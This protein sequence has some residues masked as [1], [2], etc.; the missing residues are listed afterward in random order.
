MI[1]TL[2]GMSLLIPRDPNATYHGS[3]AAPAID[4]RR[5]V[6]RVTRDSFTLQYFTRTPAAT[7]VEVREGEIPQAAYTGEKK[8]NRWSAVQV[9]QNAEGEIVGTPRIFTTLQQGRVF[10]GPAG[11]R[12]LHTISVTGL[13][14]GKR[15]FYRIYDP[16][17]TPTGPERK[18]GA[19]KPWRR[20]FAVSTQA[21]KGEKTIIHL[22]VKVILMPNVVN[23]ESGLAVNAPFPP[24]MSAA[25]I[26]RLRDDYATSAR[27]LWMASGMRLWIDYQIQIDDRWLRWGPEPANATGP[28]KGLPAS[29]S[30]PG[31]DYADPGGGDF[32]IFDSRDPLTVK[33]EPIVE[34]RPFS[35]QVEQA[36]PRRWNANTQRWDFYTS[37]GGTLGVDSFPD[38]IPGRSQFLGGGDTAWLATHEVHHQ[39]ESHGA[40]SLSNREDD[41]I[42]FD[43]PAPR[44]RVV[45]PNGSVNENAW[46]TN[47][48]HG[49]HWDVISF[50]DRQLTDAQW[51]RMYFGYT[52][53]TKDADE[54]GF[55]DNDPRLPL[56]E[57]RFGST[58]LKKQS[59]G[60][61]GDLAKAM[62][63]NWTPGP[64]QPTWT[65]PADQSIR[66]APLKPDTDGDGIVDAEDSYPL[67]PWT[68]LIMPQRATID[69]A[70]AE[71]TGVSPAATFDK[72]GLRF[73]FKQSHD[74]QAYYG[75][76]EIHGPWRR[77]DGTFDAEGKGVYSEEGVLGFQVTH[78]GESG[79]TVRP[80]FGGA[81]GLKIV[82]R[83]LAGGGTGIEFSLPNRGDGPWYWDGGGREI[84]VAL[85]VWDQEMR[86]Y[87]AY[88]PYRLFYARMVESNGE[89]PLPD[90]PPG[91]PEP[92]QPGV[93]VYRPGDSAL[94]VQGGWRI[95][96]GAWRHSGEESALILPNLRAG[97]FDLFVVLEAKADAILGAFPPGI[98]SDAGH[99]YIGFVGG[100]S[101][102]VTRMRVFGQERGDSAVVMTPGRH[103][104]QLTRRAGEL[105]LLLD[106]KPLIY[107]PDANPK[108]VVDRLAVLGGYGGAQVVHEIRIRS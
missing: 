16:G 33:R 90:N 40:F 30:Y 74:D 67:Y 68:P 48:R 38:G 62:Q 39:L 13:N 19:D 102:T 34:T 8:L 59:D 97:N 54:D 1:A 31:R 32:T 17:A 2:L 29:R 88:E 94:L 35:S 24:K 103:T 99:G 60:R 12:T 14:P 41:R 9:V 45:L 63:S 57:R 53:T 82:S 6:T 85:N 49:E 7:I 3:D 73:T 10:M 93:K 105:W 23:V 92:G 11:K 86:G 80:T 56:D 44:K 106:G 4:P 89:A 69:G 72:G 50:W 22:P 84:G 65:R 5:P 61:L 15:Y 77:I 52:T 100:Y 43:H 107:T 26:Q 37:G 21:A 42:V 70:F 98:P 64:L 28:Y 25:D 79:I 46:T 81:P 96:D 55:P 27:V 75:Y 66:P 87:S 95:E 36:F 83:N 104:M 20:E 18:W 76:Y 108:A 47:G 71:W 101:N 51:L 58:S 91:T 78:T